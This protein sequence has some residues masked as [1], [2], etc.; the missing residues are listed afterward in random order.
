MAEVMITI[1]G[2]Q[3]MIPAPELTED[4]KVEIRSQAAKQAVKDCKEQIIWYFLNKMANEDE[5]Y[6]DCAWAVDEFLTWLDDNRE[7]DYQ[8]LLSKDIAGLLT[9]CEAP[10]DG[11]ADMEEYLEQQIHHKNAYRVHVSYKRTIEDELDIVILA[12]D[13]DEVDNY[14][15]NANAEDILDEVIEDHCAEEVEITDWGIYKI[16]QEDCNSEDEYDGCLTCFDADEQ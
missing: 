12:H 5:K 3:V 10:N 8:N 11:K 15:E 16:E 13:C 9:W 7:W 6:A 1:N 2:K 14:L 4:E